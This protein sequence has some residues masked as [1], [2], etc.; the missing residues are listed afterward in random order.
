MS[1][2]EN[3]TSVTTVNGIDA[4]GDTLVYSISGIDSSFFTIDTS[5]G[6]L[7]F[8]TAPDYESPLDNDGNNIYYIKISVSDGD[9]STPKS[10]YITVTDDETE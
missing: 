7:N 5:S 4:D 3:I 9:N 2:Q 10:L 1:I 8:N 6:E